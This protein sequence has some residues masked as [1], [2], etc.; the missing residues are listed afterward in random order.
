MKGFGYSKESEDRTR[1]YFCKR[2][3]LRSL[4]FIWEVG[5]TLLGEVDVALRF[6]W[7]FLTRFVECHHSCLRR[8]RRRFEI[9]AEQNGLGE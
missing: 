9:C 4:L 3:L 8:L 7:K 6:R 2:G 1:W 5:N